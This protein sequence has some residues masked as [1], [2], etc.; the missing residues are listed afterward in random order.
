[1][2]EINKPL[3]PPV[4]VIITNNYYPT[5][6][7]IST[8]VADLVSGL[9]K[10]NIETLL[11]YPS[12]KKTNKLSRIIFV[13]RSIVTIIKLNIKNRV[14]VHSHSANF[15][16]LIGYI[17]KKLIKLKAVHTFHSPISAKHRELSFLVKGIDQLIYVSKA[18][19]RL[20]QSYGVPPFDN[21]VIIPGG[22]DIDKYLTNT[23]KKIDADNVKVLFVGRIAK[24][25]GIKE[26]I[27]SLNYL[28][29]INIKLDII[30]SAQT[31]E[32]EN[33]LSEIYKT[34]DDHTLKGSINIVGKKTGE[35]LISYYHKADIFILPSIWEEPAPMVI[36][37]A[38]SASLPIIAF[39]TGGLRERIIDSVNGVLVPRGDIEALATS[40][41]ALIE[42]K[43][44][45]EKMSLNARE[46]SLKNLSS[47]KMIEKHTSAY[48]E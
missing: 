2:E 12:Y 21:D 35:E 16:L 44:L 26:A 22:I 47:E 46:Y 32:Q 29:D 45:Y 8:Y 28:V 27:L 36:A 7:G 3:K 40:L 25:K 4:V 38:F 5:I 11:L 23:I 6:G 9:R 37:E 14:I 33:Y 15:C 18:T 31:I 30:G 20:Y 10:S 34:I 13:I 43:I 48:F 42:D 39:D 1:M 19:E 24:E 41:R 17:S